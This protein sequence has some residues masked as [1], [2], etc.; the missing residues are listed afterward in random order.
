MAREDA[1]LDLVYW[2]KQEVGVKLVVS[3]TSLR[4]GACYLF[5]LVS[6]LLAEGGRAPRNSP[7]GCGPFEN[8]CVDIAPMALRHR[9]TSH[10][11][12][13]LRARTSAKERGA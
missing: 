1:R 10:G 2:K 9:H 13:M 5:S 8:A 4:D 11:K 6:C 12:P 7:R 3:P